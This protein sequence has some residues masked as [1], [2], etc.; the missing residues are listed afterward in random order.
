MHDSHVSGSE[1]R[2]ETVSSLWARAA[3]ARRMA[4]KLIGDRAEH[5]LL[6]LA[7]ELEA[8]AMRAAAARECIKVGAD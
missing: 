2:D 8:Q 3:R 7:D 6:A 5:D 4:L 1:P